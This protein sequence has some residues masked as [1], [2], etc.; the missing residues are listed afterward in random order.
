MRV[1]VTNDDGIIA[2]G[3]AVLERIAAQF[4][5]EVWTVA[6]ETDQSGIGHALTLSDPL[7]LREV[8]ERR[9][10]VN[11]TPADC[12]ICGVRTIMPELPDLILSG[13]NQGQNIADDVVYSG[14]IGGA[15]E[16]SLM[17][18]KA[19]AVSQAYRWSEG[20][21]VPWQTVERYGPD[22]L[23]RLATFE[24]PSGTFL[25]VNFPAVDANEVQGVRICHQGKVDHNLHAEERE[26]GRGKPY[27]WLRFSRGEPRA[28]PGSDLAALSEGYVSVTPLKFDLTAHDVMEGLAASLSQSAPAAA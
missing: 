21:V 4:A 2:N 25:N 1:L 13:V 11:G 18:L 14:T 5:S 8:G 19:I 24:Q 10:A 20:R 15:M 22:L 26:D 28:A 27:H 6:P 7:R 12:V 17:G 3:L 16:G 23:R 9:Y